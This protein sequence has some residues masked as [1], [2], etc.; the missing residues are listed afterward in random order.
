MGTH[1]ICILKA[2]LLH[3]LDTYELLRGNEEADLVHE[4]N[5]PTLQI[6]LHQTFSDVTELSILSFWL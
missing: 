2:N 1:V 3:L 6:I 5:T 4:L